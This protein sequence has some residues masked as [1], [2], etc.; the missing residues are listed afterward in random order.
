MPD[1]GK[2]DRDVIQ[3]ISIYGYLLYLECKKLINSKKYNMWVILKN[4]GQQGLQSMKN[5]G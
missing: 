3:G 1:E 5:C 2:R 4:Q